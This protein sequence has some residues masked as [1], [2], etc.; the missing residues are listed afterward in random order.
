M[1]ADE[2]DH[3]S[4]SDDDILVLLGKFIRDNTNLASVK[5]MIGQFCQQGKQALFLPDSRGQSLLN[6]AVD[7]L[8]VPVVR[9]FLLQGV[10]PNKYWV[11]VDLSPEPLFKA[12]LKRC[13]VLKSADNHSID[14]LFQIARL[15][16][17]HKAVTDFTKPFRPTREYLQEQRQQLDQEYPQVINFNDGALC[18]CYAVHSALLIP[19]REGAERGRILL[20]GMLKELSRNSI[21][22]LRL[23]ST[24]LKHEEQISYM[25][26]RKKVSLGKDH[27]QC[28]LLREIY[29]DD[30]LLKSLGINDQRFDRFDQDLRIREECRERLI[31]CLDGL[32]SAANSLMESTYTTRL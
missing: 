14:P 29:R 24:E 4:P 28:D 3:T 12:I 15:F 16:W 2:S 1:Q 27:F 31:T 7:V 19:D 13:L 11:P 26:Q 30:T 6:D 32:I 22:V 21:R 10:D 9:E 18:L 8:S 5:K 20:A 25:A 23:L 17:I